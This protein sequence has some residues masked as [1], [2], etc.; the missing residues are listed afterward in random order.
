M[1]NECYLHKNGIMLDMK[2]IVEVCCQTIPHFDTDRPIWDNV[3]EFDTEYK[4]TGKDFEAFEKSKTE[5]LDGC[6]GCRL[7]EERFGFSGRNVANTVCN[8]STHNHIQHAIIN[9]GNHCNLACRMCDDGPSSKWGSLAREY[10]N[11][12][13]RDQGLI[14]HNKLTKSYVKNKVLTKHLR[15]LTFAGGE[16]LLSKTASEYLVHML[17][18]DIFDE[19][20]E[21]HLI[22][23]GTFALSEVWKESF[24][25]SNRV[26]LSFSMDGTGDNYNYIRE[27]AD[28]D[29][30]LANIS[31]IVE[32]FQGPNFVF[33][34]TYCLQAAN[35]HK[36]KHDLQ[37]FKEWKSQYYSRDDDEFKPNVITHPKYLSL[38]CVHPDLIKKY[39]I[40]NEATGFEFSPDDYKEF[41]IFMGFW[42]YRFGKSLEE[43]NP[44]FFDDNYYP[45]AREYYNIGKNDAKFKTK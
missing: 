1:Q 44:D 19:L 9:P 4:S 43:Q 24:R 34:V 11:K 21:L 22:T 40:E 27:Y 2:G 16:P 13:M 35:A 36:W 10:P 14:K 31:N 39:D 17:E 5:W 20:T 26:S 37:F 32:E 7:D 25:K 12:W 18:N 30:V 23:N 3:L 29:H 28:F 8:K 15:G 38:S 45:N 42:D 41:M 6:H 33:N